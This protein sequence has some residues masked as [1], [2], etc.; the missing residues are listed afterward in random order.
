MEAEKD[1]IFECLDCGREYIFTF[2]EQRYFNNKGLIWPKR[3]KEC[4]R[5]RR[6]SIEHPPEWG[7][8]Q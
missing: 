8:Q 6:A 2:G 3:C 7:E 5:K 4:R 1:L